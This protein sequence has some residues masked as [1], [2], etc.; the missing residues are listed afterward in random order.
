MSYQD[1]QILSIPAPTAL[2]VVIENLRSDL[3]ALTWLDRAFG[4]A[5]L[6]RE[7]LIGENNRPVNLP[8]VYLGAGEYQNVLPND[9]LTSQAFIATNGAET[10]GSYTTASQNAKTRQ[11]KI[12]FWFNLQTIDKDKTYIFT[13]ELKKDVELVLRNNPAIASIDEYADD[14]A[15]QVFEGYTLPEDSQYL[16]FPFAGFRFNVTVGYWEEC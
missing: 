3:S 14:S 12:V 2:D 13:E 10:W 1:P 7:L 11:L 4:R 16:M 9:H 5:W 15:E 8:K 6:F